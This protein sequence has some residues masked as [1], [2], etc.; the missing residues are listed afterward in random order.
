M[1]YEFNWFYVK[2]ALPQLM[3]GLM[4][5]LQ[6]TLWANIIGLV[7]GF[8]VAIGML[9]KIRMIVWPL[10]AYIEFFRCTPA[11][12]QLV[13][14]FFCVPI[15]FNVWWSA[16]F[17]GMLALGLNLAAF[18]AEAYRAA[19]QAIPHAHT[20]ASTAL[21]LNVLQRIIYVILPQ[22]LIL[23]LPVLITNGIGIFQQSALV[24][25]ISV[26]D[27]MYEGRYIA[28]QT[29]R[30]IETLTT[31]ALIYFAVSFPVSQAVT[32]VERRTKRLLAS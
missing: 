21:G 30:P 1:N 17:M 12:I 13:W 24:A 27:L 18:N 28:T 5:T 9:S 15:L 6:L 19:I 2:K 31:V 10:T 26:Q 22:A 29:F 4:V 25:L 20:D 32:L 11:L 14:F 7:L 8:I 16:E 3:D 23:A